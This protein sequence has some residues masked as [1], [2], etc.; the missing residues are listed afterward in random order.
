MWGKSAAVW[1]RLG[2]N[3]FTQKTKNKREKEINS[4]NRGLDDG[5]TLSSWMT[6]VFPLNSHTHQQIRTSVKICFPTNE[7]KGAGISEV[8]Q[9]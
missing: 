9:E 6:V 7:I 4:K 5:Q 1:V 8:G 3:P 2:L